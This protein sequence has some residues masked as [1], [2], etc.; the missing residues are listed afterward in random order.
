MIDLTLKKMDLDKDG[1]ICY[2]DFEETVKSEPLLLEAFGTCLPRER[3]L[4]S[5]MKIIL[6]RPEGIQTLK[7]F[8]LGLT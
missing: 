5:F 7:N 8:Y 6:D 1:R 3:Q 2:E 4:D